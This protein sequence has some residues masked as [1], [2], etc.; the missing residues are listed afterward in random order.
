[1]TRRRLY[2]ANFPT[3]RAPDGTKAIRIGF[4]IGYWPCHRAPYAQ[5]AYGPAALTL[6]FALKRITTL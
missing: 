5:I 1:M 4:C 2:F 6:Y 3:K